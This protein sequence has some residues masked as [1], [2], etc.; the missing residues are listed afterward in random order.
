[1][2][3]LFLKLILACFL[4]YGQSIKALPLVPTVPAGYSTMPV[5]MSGSSLSKLFVYNP[6]DLIGFKMTQNGWIQIPIQIDERDSISGDVIFNTCTPFFKS[7]VQPFKSLQ[8]C[9]ANTWVGNDRNV[10][11]D[12]DDELVFLV[13][14]V[15]NALNSNPIRP[16]GVDPAS[17]VE[18]KVTYNGGTPIGYIYVFKRTITSLISSAWKTNINYQFRLNSGN[19]KTTYNQTTGPNPETSYITTKYYH[20]HFSDRWIEDELFINQTATAHLNIIDRNTIRIPS[21]GCAYT[22]QTF[23]NS[24]GA[25][26]VNKTGPIRAIRSYMGDNNYQLCQRDHFLYESMDFTRTYIRASSIQNL[27]LTWDYNVNAGSMIYNNNNN[28]SSTNTLVTYNN[29]AYKG[30]VIE[31]TP[32]GYNNYDNFVAGPLVWE[33]INS[34][35]GSVF[36]Y[37]KI[38]T[39]IPNFISSS[40]FKDL[41]ASSPCTGDPNDWGNSGLSF[42]AIPC[43]DPRFSTY[44]KLVLE[45]WN[46]YLPMETTRNQVD[47]LKLG[48][49][50]P[51]QTIVSSVPAVNPLALDYALIPMVM[52]GSK[53][54]TL[55]TWLP[56]EII[57]FKYQGQWEQ[58]PIQIDEKRMMQAFEIYNLSESYSSYYPDYLL[59]EYCDKN[60]GVGE[61]YYPKFDSDDELVF[62]LKDVGN[63]AG[64]NIK[65]IGVN[66]SI[67]GVK[68]TISGHNGE[69]GYIY[70]FKKGTG[71]NLIPSAGKS[72]VNYHF[73][74]ESGD[75]TLEHY[76]QDTG[77]YNLEKSYIQTPYYHKHFLNRWVEDDLFISKGDYTPVDLIDRQRIY[78]LITATKNESDGRTENTFSDDEGAFLVNKSGPI[79]GIRSYVGANSGPYTQQDHFMYESSEE[80]HLYLRVHSMSYLVYGWDHNPAAG[81]MVYNN[82]NNMPNVNVSTENGITYKGICIDGGSLNSYYPDNFVTGPLNWELVNSHYGSIL[83]HN[84]IISNIRADSLIINSLFKDAMNPVLP[85]STG[86]LHHYGSSGISTYCQLPNT[87]PS[88]VDPCR[89]FELKQ[90]NVFLKPETTLDDAAEI[91]SLIDNPVAVGVTPW[92]P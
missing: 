34:Y 54:P 61:D 46:L 65:P 53:L 42:G 60:T 68:V 2:K 32:T 79:R 24:Y 45:E 91:R 16:T 26:M 1:M 87:D 15:G 18:I 43:T 81:Y 86:D 83:R 75:T 52:E 6:S 50:D 23:A 58:I 21:A 63:L 19:Y 4:F 28:H 47:T 5:V 56:D 39:D 12:S 66:N 29:V 25:F 33:L 73:E 10:L 80:R 71:S 27:Q 35:S 82:N 22:E 92:N 7:S 85:P 49:Q 67:P 76:N 38:N 8:Y 77:Y 14:D 9:D 31:G 84:T 51:V 78:T 36:R 48:M 55:N 88:L 20:K 90:W 13:K 62:M 70:L 30:I 40:C 59:L 11:F 3:K 41:M 74:L 69:V 57:G 64:T 44:N 89:K 37:H 72:Y 17:G